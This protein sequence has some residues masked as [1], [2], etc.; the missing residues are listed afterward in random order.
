MPWE[1]HLRFAESRP[2]YTLR[3]TF[4]EDQ[5][6]FYG[7]QTI[8]VGDRGAQ[9]V[10]ITALPDFVAT[11]HVRLAGLTEKPRKASID[12]VGEGLMTRTDFNSST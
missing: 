5:R 12:F 8:E 2:D 1:D 3:A 6:V 7:E 10:Q 11:G 4:T 9:N